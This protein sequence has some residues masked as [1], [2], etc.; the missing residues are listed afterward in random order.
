MIKTVIE[1]RPRHGERYKLL[2]VTPSAEYMVAKSLNLRGWN[3]HL[4][5]INNAVVNHHIATSDG[6]AM[7]VKCIL[8][9]AKRTKKVSKKQMRLI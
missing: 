6:H 2:Y 8:P 5:R 9:E 7:D 3:A 4:P 1:D